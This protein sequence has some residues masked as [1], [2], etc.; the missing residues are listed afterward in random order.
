[1]KSKQRQMKRST[2]TKKETKSAKSSPGIMATFFGRSQSYLT[3]YDSRDDDSR[4][5]SH[6]TDNTRSSFDTEYTTAS[7]QALEPEL[8][9]KH[10]TACKHMKNGKFDEALKEFEDILAAILAQYGEVHQRVGAA[11]HNVG[12]ANLRAGQ[13]DDAMDATEEAIRIRKVTLGKEDPKVADSLVELGIILL[14]MKE[15]TDALEIFYEA[16]ELREFE[17]EE[18]VL[19]EDVE[20]SNMKIA[21]VMNNIGCVNFERGNFKDAKKA[22]AD[23]VK[24]QKSTL[25]GTISDYTASKPGVLTMATTMCN[26]GYVHLNLSEYTEASKIFEESLQI[27]KLL[28]GADNKLILNTLDNLGFSNAMKASYEPAIK[29]YDALLANQQKSYDQTPMECADTLRKLVWIRLQLQL[30]DETLENLCLL[31]DNQI[32]QFG[33]DSKEVMN[34]QELMGQVNYQ[35]LKYPTLVETAARAFN[36][37]NVCQ[38]CTGQ[39][40]EDRDEETLDSEHWRPLAPTNSSKMSGHRVTYA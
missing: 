26:K 14:S 16:L 18:F 38:S 15:Y 11:L 28:L 9:T 6:S 23:A 25:G 31:E 17:S 32:E 4:L 36:Q 7:Q 5:M 1:M 29:I 12:I 20:E 19:P 37:I 8:R 24:L 39:C 40:Q 27:Q 34:T 35:V 13:L 33:E 22:F 2:L 30:W 21:K 3:D 10:A